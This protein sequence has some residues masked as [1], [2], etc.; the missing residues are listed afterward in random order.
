MDSTKQRSFGFSVIERLFKLQEEHCDTTGWC[1]IP[2]RFD[3]RYV[4]PV[5]VPFE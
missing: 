1:I 2:R 4:L 3:W 5:E